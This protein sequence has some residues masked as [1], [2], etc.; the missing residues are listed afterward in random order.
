[1]SDPALPPHRT[2]RVTL[3]KAQLRTELG[4]ELLSL[5]QSITADGRL[6]PEEIAGL[7]DWLADTEE[8]DLPAISYLRE[9]VVR[10]LADGQ[11]TPDEYQ[12]LYKAVEAVLPPEVR[13]QAIAARREV[14]RA[15]KAAA[16][17]ERDA[18]RQRERDERIRN[19]P[20]ASANFMVAGVR[21]EGRPAVID[22]YAKVDDSISLV[23]VPGNSFSNAAIAVMLP[24]G[25]QIGFVPEDDAQYLAP[26]LDD[27]SRCEARIT[28]ILTAG[29]S[30]IPVVQAHL[31]PSGT[32]ESGTTARRAV[33]KVSGGAESTG[34]RVGRVA[35]KL[36]LSILLWIAVGVLI[37]IVLI[38]R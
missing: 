7:R 31:Y 28:R 35:R 5:C 9:I 38:A 6:A 12:E 17:A 15:D 3:T 27:G 26:H 25:K 1:M 23:R 19:R 33:A 16:R 18:E 14:E 32:S 10:V 4:A 8:S 30:P 34:Y 2:R 20:I 11:I 37:L 24:N 22:R 21:H 13:R 36:K 29:R